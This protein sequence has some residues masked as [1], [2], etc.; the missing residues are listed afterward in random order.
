MRGCTTHD[1]EDR[2]EV[3][4]SVR[5]SC[6]WTAPGCSWTFCPWKTRSWDQ[7]V[8]SRIVVLI[9][10]ILSGQM[11]GGQEP[12]SEI[13]QLQRQL[14]AQQERI[15]RLESRSLAADDSNELRRLT[16]VT[17]QPPE[18][19][20]ESAE[21]TASPGT[22]GSAATT[23]ETADEEPPAGLTTLA[24]RVTALEDNTLDLRGAQTRFQEAFSQVSSRVLNGRLHV[25]QWT[26]PQSSEGINWIENGDPNLDPLSEVVFRRVRFGLHGEVPPD[27]MSYRVEIEFSGQDGGRIRDAWLAWDELFVFDTLR[28][29]NQKRPYGLDY[30]NSSNFMVFMER[31]FVVEAFNENVRRFGLMSYGASDDQAIN[32][33][34]GVA[35]LELIQNTGQFF[36][37]RPQPELM[38]RLANAWWYDER[39]LGRGYGHWGVSAVF[40]L[41][42]R[43]STQ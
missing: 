28:L 36:N 40:R 19:I 6:E 25:D 14:R 23:A 31:P 30:L 37:E 20:D 43:R 42:R 41:H 13:E 1:R 22:E 10:W 26:Y 29:G 11:A 3:S 35:A 18:E 9:I 38:G 32:W 21:A 4:P 39:S 7:Q 12:R 34:Y 24:E 33:R 15:E 17:D 27:N 2:P 5:W 16:P 8:L